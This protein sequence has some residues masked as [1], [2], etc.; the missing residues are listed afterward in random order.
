MCDCSPSYREV[1]TANQREH[2]ILAL[3]RR[4]QDFE[5]R[6]ARGKRGETARGVTNNDR[7]EVTIDEIKGALRAAVDESI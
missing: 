3:K 5:N 4:L 1:F 7:L 6:L 2:V